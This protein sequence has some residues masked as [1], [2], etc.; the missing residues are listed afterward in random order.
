MQKTTADYQPIINDLYA[1]MRRDYESANAPSVEVLKSPSK[2][3][4]LVDVSYMYTRNTLKYLAVFLFFLENPSKKVRF[5]FAAF[6][7]GTFWAFYRKM[8]LI[9]VGFSLISLMA[10]PLITSDAGDFIYIIALA[11]FFGFYGNYF[12]FQFLLSRPKGDR[13]YPGIIALLGGCV[14]TMIAGGLL[15][16]FMQSLTSLTSFS[17]QAGSKF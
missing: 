2:R 4:E 3:T 11:L 6:L 12:Y 14:L 16:T 13:V 8:F 15:V 1:K 5:N 9:G 7:F 10:K 17:L